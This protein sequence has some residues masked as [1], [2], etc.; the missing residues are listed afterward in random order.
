MINARKLRNGRSR[1]ISSMS[2]INSLRAQCLTNQRKKTEWA[3]E[4]RLT[5]RGSPIGASTEMTPS[6]HNRKAADPSRGLPSAIAFKFQVL[7]LC[8]H[9]DRSEALAERSRRTPPRFVPC[10]AAESISPRTDPTAGRH[11]R[12][13]RHAPRGHHR[14]HC[15][16]DRARHGAVRH[17]RRHLDAA[18]DLALAP[19]PPPE[20]QHHRD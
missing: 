17:H 5:W 6:C 8:C 15:V 18:R 13:D 11:A 12:R 4:D 3:I 10:N 9:P 14:A 20:R 16:R 2:A 19:L 1:P 7:V